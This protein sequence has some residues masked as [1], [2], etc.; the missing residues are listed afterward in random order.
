MSNGKLKGDK[1]KVNAFGIIT[2]RGGEYK[3]CYRGFYG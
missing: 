1:K 3:N 2:V